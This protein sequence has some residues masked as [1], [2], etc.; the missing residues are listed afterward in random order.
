MRA[1]TI[2][3]GPSPPRGTTMATPRPLPVQY[4][5]ASAPSRAAGS[6]GASAADGLPEAS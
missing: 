4:V 1:S 2:A 3:H 6:G 5:L